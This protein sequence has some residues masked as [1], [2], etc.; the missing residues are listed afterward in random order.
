MAVLTVALVFSVASPVA[1]Q[2]QPPPPAVP[3]PPPAGEPT[4]GPTFTL[5]SGDR[6]RLDTAADGTKDGVVVFDAEPRGDVEFQQ[7]DRDLHA[8]PAAA[9]PL[10]GTGRLDRN[11]F[12]LDRLAEFGYDDA[13][14]ATLP[15]IA[16]YPG[17]GARAARAVPAGAK[18]TRELPAVSAAALSVDKK[19]TGG[20]WSEVTGEG[21]RNRTSAPVRKL[22]LDGKVTASLDVS[23]PAVG[24]PRA[25]SAGFDGTGTKIAVL[26]TGI[27]ADHPDVAGRIVASKSFVPGLGVDDR[28]GHGTHVA[29][30]A[31]GTGA[32]SDGRYRGV[33][34]NAG[35]IVGKVLDDT[36]TGLN[37]E[38]IAGM[39]WAA[40]QGADVINMSLGGQPT[41]GTD[42][43]SQ[44]LNRISSDTGALFVVAAGNNEINETVNTPGSAD[45]ALTV[46]AVDKT[47]PYPLA[48]YTSRGPRILDHAVKPEIAAPGTGIVAARAEGTSML[49]RGIIVDDWY[50]QAHGTSM[51]TPHVAGAAAILA[52]QHP[53]WTGEQLKDVLVSSADRNP[54]NGPAGE[55]GGMLDVAAATTT[56]IVATGT[57]NIGVAEPPYTVRHGKATFRN[58]SDEAVHA[59]LT[60]D[61]R[62][63]L[64]GMAAITPAA[65]AV[66]VTP[67]TVDIPAGGSVTVDI[68][69]DT[70]KFE[71]DTYFAYLTA[72][73]GD[74][75]RTHTTMSWRKSPP[76]HR[77]IITG[78]DRAGIPASTGDCSFVNILNLGTG[79]MIP[80]WWQDGRA[81]TWRYG[82]PDP[83]LPEGRYAVLGNVCTYTQEAPYFLLSDTIGGDI[84][85]QLDRDRKIDIDARKAER[86]EFHTPRPSEQ[87][88]TRYRGRAI[89]MLAFRHVMFED[90][91]GVWSGFL[92]R[93]SVAPE[94]Y[95]VPNRTTATTGEFFTQ[96]TSHR[97]APALTMRAHGR[98]APV[99]H[100]WYP[101]EGDRSSCAELEL[102]F[103]PF[104]QR[105]RYEVVRVG[106]GTAA[107]SGTANV[108]GKVV[109]VDEQWGEQKYWS[110]DAPTVDSVAAAAAAAGAAGVLISAAYPGWHLRHQQAPTTIPVATL[111][112]AEGRDLA[113]ALRNGPV[114]ISTGGQPVSPYVYD[115]ATE[116]DRLTVPDPSVRHRNLATINARYHTDVPGSVSSTGSSGLTPYTAHDWTK[117]RAPH[118][119]TEYVS[120]PM[121]SAISEKSHRYEFLRVPTGAVY[122]VAP[123]QHAAGTR[124]TEDYGTAPV[125]SAP[126]SQPGVIARIYGTPNNPLGY[127]QPSLS[128]YRSPSGQVSG[129]PLTSSGWR[130]SRD[131][132]T[133]CERD[134]MNFGFSCRASGNGRYRLEVGYTQEVRPTSTAT[135]TVW[136]FHAT[137]DHPVN[138][139]RTV[140]VVDLRYDVDH[141]SL[142][143][144]V[145]AGRPYR[146]T[147][148]V[149]YQS[150]YTGP[151]SRSYDVEVWTSADDGASW[152][153]AGGKRADRRGD[154]T[155]RLTAPRDKGFVTIRVKAADASGN[156]IDQTI[157]RAWKV[158]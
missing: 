119:R 83:L 60:L 8:L 20:V 94:L 13:S 57:V 99:L 43:M 80:G 73:D 102:C 82:G 105:G 152:Q 78:T 3:E 86:V 36:G 12:N 129:W 145:R 110:S 22:W 92:R 51:A 140:P 113:K 157:T 112:A 75:V 54:E 138:S 63:G 1:A 38:I 106:N 17:A 53:D 21:E 18:R 45:R 90:E 134:D 58:L 156:S 46:G 139:E 19:N 77:L 123:R 40:E 27:D 30:I 132:E 6:V 29:S 89:G 5:L 71:I 147:F 125:V 25:W 65:G 72:K 115:L 56:D 108:R 97:T 34:P 44:A 148:N 41:D 23:V 84:E 37:S 109:L 32:A 149:G 50:L 155:F 127:L 48:Y 11:L 59:D 107:E 42:P 39:A 124:V 74:T 16:T 100:P 70:T 136:D 66:T 116:V 87:L 76:R 135:H 103:P 96:F 101:A 52:Q 153:R 35:L 104:D 128:L 144:G 151:R 93:A 118:T 146:A 33:A 24:A 141:L 98:R 55:G 79:E 28:V 4:E 120:P 81:H 111:S 62:K 49:G 117:F 126:G 122:E 14:S 9:V 150:A 69:V 142:T 133:L 15:V 95:V 158:E 154:A 31:A 26:D 61:V 130:F 143:N 2:P 47:E 121:P 88:A 67:S 64:Q 10:I 7:I 114:R 68:A 91:T 85:F 131:G 137:F